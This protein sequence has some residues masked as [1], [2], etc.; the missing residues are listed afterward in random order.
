MSSQPNRFAYLLD[1]VASL[2]KRQQY[3]TALET[4]HVLSQAAM[5]QNLQLILQRY[6]AEL[7]MECLEL[8]G[9]LKTALDIC[10]HSIQQ[11]QLQSEPLSTDAQKDLITLEL[12][13]LC[14]LIKL[15]RRNEA[16]IQ[17]KHIL[18]LCSLKQQISLQP[19]ITRLNRFSSASHIHLTKEQKHI[20]L[21]H[22]SEKLINEGAEAFS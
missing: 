16:S 15:D 13:K 1:Q 6:L 2:L 22:L 14:L 20:G 4:L 7:S 8:C 12:R 17:S 19:V 11:Y 3:D 18:T 10:E 9:Q 21:F 5:Q